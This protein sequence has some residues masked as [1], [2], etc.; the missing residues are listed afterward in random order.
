MKKILALVLTLAMMLTM[1]NVGFVAS[2]AG[3]EIPAGATAINDAAGLAGMQAGGTYYLAADITI[4]SP[5]TLNEDAN[6]DPIADD[7]LEMGEEAEIITIPAGV[8]LYGNGKTIYM[9]YY[10]TNPAPY[11]NSKG[12]TGPGTYSADWTHGMF[13]ASAGDK[14]TFIDVN[15]GSEELPIYLDQKIGYPDAWSAIGMF[16]DEAGANVEFDGVDFYFDRQ[17]GGLNNANLGPIGTN[18]NGS[19]TFK[20]CT[21]SGFISNGSQFG[22]WIYKLNNAAST[23]TMDNCQ[24]YGT[25]NGSYGGGIIHSMNGGVNITITNYTN[26]AAQNHSYGSGSGGFWSTMVGNF[27]G[28]VDDGELYMENC[29]NY[30]RVSLNAPFTIGGTILART[31]SKVQSIQLINCDNYGKVTRSG[32]GVASNHGYGALAGHTGA[33]TTYTLTG[34]D[35]YADIQG[36]ACFGGLI[37]LKEGVAPLNLTNCN[38]HGNLTASTVACQTVGGI[39]GQWR[40]GGT[41]ENCVNYG[42]ISSAGASGDVYMAGMA[43]NIGSNDLAEGT[44]V[45]NLEN[46]VNYGTIG[47]TNINHVAGMI[48]YKYN[49]TCQIN[50]TGCVNHGQ[51]TGKTNVGGMIAANLDS[52]VSISNSKNFGAIT[53]TT[54]AGGIVGTSSGAT[55]VSGSANYGILRGNTYTG[56]IVGAA[57]GTNTIS[58]SANY[59]ALTSG[60]TVGGIIAHVNASAVIDIDKC[61]NAGSIGT[62]GTGDSN[63]GVGGFIGRV[64]D[65]NVKI[66]I[67]DSA[68]TATVTGSRKASSY[69]AFGDT[70]GQFIGLYTVNAGYYYYAGNENVGGFW[71]WSA[72]TAIKPKLTNCYAYGQALISTSSP[73]SLTG[74]ITKDSSTGEALATNVT[75]TVAVTAAPNNGIY[76][77]N[78]QIDANSTVN[79]LGDTPVNTAIANL[80]TALGIDMMAGTT[81]EDAFVVA[82]PEIRGYQI[83]NDKTAIRF[84]AVVS[85]LN[86]EDLGFQYTVSVNG[87]TKIENAT[88]ACGEVWTALN[89]TAADGSI[90][91]QTAADMCGKYITAITF[92]GIP[93]EGTVVITVKPIANDGT[94]VGTAYTATI[95]DGVVTSVVAA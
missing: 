71:D 22:G 10:K 1:L 81:G 39:V 36:T 53:A 31:A 91:A 63:E 59:A 68:N 86:Y 82:T 5:I 61:L 6:G 72:N 56:G 90:K 38:N 55:T 47:A 23:L 8:T 73:K 44:A 46:C 50:L 19:Y 94:Y 54:T 78:V 41:F 9:G 88:K 20:N 74:W 18:L 77:I 2:A 64:A 67:D 28:V 42:T 24:A 15:F 17:N 58:G 69:G 89:A 65:T 4:G 16:E 7:F 62:P 70:F 33:N 79:T 30:G 37:G 83:S 40:D 51:L 85:S 45:F 43:G 57:S 49:K 25:V 87:D 12:I 27:G 26:Y 66:T 3:A 76:G 60:H 95:T 13:K 80:K 14:I 92:R 52:T 34:C 21:K 48:A 75:S 93:A 35:N 11:T 84:A 29:V 32:D